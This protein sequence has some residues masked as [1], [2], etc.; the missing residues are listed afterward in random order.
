MRSARDFFKP[1]AV[2]APQ[3]LHEIEVS[4][5][6]M[7]HFFPPH[8]EGVR[9]RIPEVR[10][11]LDAQTYAE[12]VEEAESVELKRH[13]PVINIS[14]D[15]GK[16]KRGGRRRGKH[17]CKVAANTIFDLKAPLGERKGGR[18]CFYLGRF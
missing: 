5:S 2:G 6:R 11:W 16:K 4:P 3:P 1:L 15:H 10:F 13:E 9:K 12:Q 17:V 14:G 8:N 18:N 7:I